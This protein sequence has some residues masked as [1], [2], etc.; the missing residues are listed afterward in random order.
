MKKENKKNKKVEEEK[1]IES[2]IPN[3]IDTQKEEGKDVSLSDEIMREIEDLKKENKRVNDL[4]IQVADKKQLAIYYQ[5]NREKVPPVVKLR[6][7]GDKV[8][9][10]WRTVYDKVDQDPVTLRW[11][12]KQTVEVLYE[13]GK[14]QQFALLDYVKLYTHIEAD[15][16]ST[17]TDTETGKIA[18]KVRTRDGREYV[19]GAEFVN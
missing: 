10:G 7:I 4:L 18:F 5:R 13:D 15:V 12:E 19:I 1:E 17:S 2:N 9:M 16:L 14:S 8:I 6:T 3:D 11:R